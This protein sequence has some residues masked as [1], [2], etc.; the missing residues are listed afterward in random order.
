MSAGTGETYGVDGAMWRAPDGSHLNLT[1]GHGLSPGDIDR[2]ENSIW[3]YASAIRVDRATAITLGEGWTPFL[4]SQWLGRETWFKLEYLAP[5]GSFKDRGTSVLLSYLR[6]VGIDSI[7][8]DSSGNAG[9][10]MC[11][12]AA[13]GGLRC[14]V[15]VPAAIPQGKAVQMVGM[16]ADVTYVEGTRQD[17]ADAALRLAQDMFYAS[18]NWQ[19]YFLEGT[20]T[21]AFELWEQFGFSVPDDV[22]VP[23]GYGSNVLGLWLGFNELLSCGAIDRLPRI[24][25]VQA[26]NCAAF[27]TAWAAGTDEWTRFEPRPTVADGIASV[28]PVRMKEVMSAVRLS[29]GSIVTVSEEEI[30]TALKALMAQGFFVEPTSATAGAALTRLQASPEAAL[31]SKTAAILTG[32]GLKATQCIADILGSPNPSAPA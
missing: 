31:G 1:P 12:Y 24:H 15:L 20:K 7:L 22:V 29:G 10:S 3:R 17:V 5:T 26:E 13:A 23:L 2:E 25:G 6:S 4:K 8:E 18:H 27:G 11:A 21:L 19:P 9:A 30:A 14:K 16:G 28:R 32:S